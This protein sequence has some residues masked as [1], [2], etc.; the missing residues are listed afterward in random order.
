MIFFFSFFTIISS[1]KHKKEYTKDND[2]VHYM[3]ELEFRNTIDQYDLALVLFFKKDVEECKKIL[4]GYRLAAHKSIGKADF[5]AVTAKSA[6]DLCDELGVDTFPTIFSFR[7]GHFVEKLNRTTAKELYEYVKSVTSAKYKYIHDSE[8]VEET[9]LKK[10]VTLVIAVEA[11]DARMDKL[12]DEITTK[13]FNDIQIVIATNSEIANKFHI[14]DFPSITILRNQDDGNVKFSGNP[15]KATFKSLSDFVQKNIKPRYRLMKSTTEINDRLCFV[16]LFDTTNTNDTIFAK[17]VLERVSAD[18]NEEFSIWYADALQ[19]R[20]N[21]TSMLIN[22]YHLP[23]FMFI[24]KDRFGYVKY[25]FKGKPSPAALSAFWSDQ[26]RGRNTPTLV[27]SPVEK[28][29][30]FVKRS[31]LKYLMGTELFDALRKDKSKD[32]IVNFVGHPCLHCDAIDDLFNETAGWAKSN[33]VRDVVFA[34]VNASCNDIPNSVWRNETFPYGWFFPA[35]NRSAAFPIGKRRQ[36]YWMVQLLVDNCTTPVTAPMP[37]KPSKTPGPIRT[38]LPPGS[39][40]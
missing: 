37:P 38:S 10:D 20:R 40:L 28:N 27:D 14:S 7:N 2:A 4:P 22:N 11:V 12:L 30:S 17:E 3:R 8:L 29:S 13:F 15:F 25:I 5:I 33:G 21:L 18:H 35:K 19:L 32:Y 36:L 26:L 24:R 16:A 31:L 34:R 9:L 1:R 6:A 39:E 23:F